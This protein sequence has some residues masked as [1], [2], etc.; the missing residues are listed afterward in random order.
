VPRDDFPIT[1][2]VRVLRSAGIA[3]T[4]FTYRYQEH[5]GTGLAARELGV[6]EHAVV[7]TLVLQTDAG[8]P[9]LLLMHGDHEASLKAFARAIG[10]KHVEMCDEK[11][12]QR[13]TGYLFGGT[14]PFGTRLPLPVFAQRSIFDLPKILI[15]GG[16][17]GF[18]I[19]MD[20]KEMR[21]ALS[22]IE[23]DAAQPAGRTAAE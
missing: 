10:V 16:K 14:S 3:F 1:P 6:E 8:R 11:A 21:K 5:G 9:L 2:C 12:A 18:L 22:V 7:K 15:N 19:E 17:R 4:P 23:V 13:H 20:P